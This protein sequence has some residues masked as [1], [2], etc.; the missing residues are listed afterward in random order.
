MRLRLL[1]PV[2][3][4]LTAVAATLG[5]GLAPAAT[6]A[7]PAL[8]GVQVSPRVVSEAGVRW[9]PWQRM[10]LTTGT[11]LTT[12]LVTAPLATNATPEHA[13]SYAFMA[14]GTDGTPV[15]WNPCA[16]VH[17]LFNPAHA[18]SGGLLAVQAAVQR[19]SSATGLSFVYDGTTTAVPTGGWLDGQVV[20]SPLPLLV[21]WSTPTES[22]LLA[23][24]PSTLVGMDR[25]MWFR[26]ASGATYIT[27]GVVALNSLI[28]AGTSGPSSWYTYALHELGH[29]VGL[30]H[31][32]DST[33]IMSPVIPAAAGDY[34]S[35]D[36][37][38]L[39]RVGGSC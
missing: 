32:S 34:G 15:R 36:L 22:T 24:Q 31:T 12:A 5:A 18:P 25:S 35:G 16:P 19:I 14:T 11:S 30:G 3:T 13:A 6:A 21:G 1:I 7:Q 2:A 39:R 23:G 20:T 28:P 29:A 37:S 38:G 26:D 9:L 27:S 17:W 10:R 8:D 33:Q 4:A